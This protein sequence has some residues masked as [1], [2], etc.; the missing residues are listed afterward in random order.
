MP[1]GFTHLGLVRELGI[2]RILMSIEGMSQ[3]IADAMQEYYSYVELGAVSPDL[4]YLTLSS[5]DWADAFH[6]QRT[7]DVVRVG[8]Q[9]LASLESS[10]KDRARAI[11][12][13]FGYVSHAV[14]DMLAHPVIALKVGKYEQHKREH[15]VCEMNQDAYV[16]SHYFGDDIDACEYLDHGIKTCTD[17]GQSGSTLAKWM[18]SFWTR[19]LS[20]VYPEK[21]DPAPA[22]W[23]GQFVTVIDGVADEGSHLILVMRGFAE[24]LGVVYPGQVDMTYV[25]RLT[26][27]FGEPITFDALFTMIQEQVKN[28]WGQLARAITANNAGLLSLPNGDFDSGLDLADGQTSIFWR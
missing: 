4:P 2:N 23:F 19:I 12:W 26:T 28:V 21:F 3:N 18:A 7:V 13:L 6:H 27:P 20:Q 25:N 24:D 10:C 5:G 9:T 14:A 11:A 17:D 15:R 1:G 22:S 16:F 8:V